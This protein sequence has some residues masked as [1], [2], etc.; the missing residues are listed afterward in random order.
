MFNS[1]KVTLNMLLFSGLSFELYIFDGLW[2]EMQE[3][4]SK[5]EK[6]YGDKEK[7]NLKS[8]GEK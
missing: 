2:F 8:E 6:K 5:I 4:D 1:Y 7:E 3:I